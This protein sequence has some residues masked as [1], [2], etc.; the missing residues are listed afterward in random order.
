MNI[1]AELS[2]NL[3]TERKS[4]MAQL[5]SRSSATALSFVMLC[6]ACGS[7]QKS[8][9]SANDV[10]A[11]APAPQTVDAAAMP[12]GQ[13]VNTPPSSPPPQGLNEPSAGNVMASPGASAPA[14]EPQLSE[15]QIAMITD[16]ANSAEV[17]QGKLAQSKAKN[18]KVKKF[19]AMMVKHH[20]EAKADQAKLFKKLAL[21]P[22]QS[23]D[24]TTLKEG[25]DRTLGALRGADGSAFD[26]AYIDSQ[27][28]E[29]QKVLD[30]IDQKLLPAA[31]GEDLTN[32][33]KKMR[34]TVESHLK[35]ARAIQAE[36][37]QTAGK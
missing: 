18:A 3:R 34:D 33:L 35:E 14:P 6:L 26:V 28:D 9:S 2:C 4:F 13:P 31:T 8:T 24:A 29:H 16:L 7:D 1:K 15:P 12:N 36:L 30:T 27:V 21:T 5:L 10:Q 19:A 11:E 25:A 17:E 20:G 23:Q 32:E 22:T 37:S